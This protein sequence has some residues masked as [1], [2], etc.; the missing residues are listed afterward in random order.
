MHQSEYKAVE[1][2]LTQPSSPSDRFGSIRLTE[3]D[4]NNVDSLNSTV[5]TPDGDDEQDSKQTLH[6]KKDLGTLGRYAGHA[7]LPISR[8]QKILKADEVPCKS[9]RVDNMVI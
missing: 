7:I 9:S 6:K 8:V 4:I 3:D 5:H 1:N 2:N